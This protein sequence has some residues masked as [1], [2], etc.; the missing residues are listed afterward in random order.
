MAYPDKIGSSTPVVPA[1]PAGDSSSRRRTFR[2]KKE[3]EPSREKD[4]GQEQGQDQKTPSSH[5]VDE[6]V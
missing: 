5:K 4:Q 1:H 2:P 6:Y 3:D